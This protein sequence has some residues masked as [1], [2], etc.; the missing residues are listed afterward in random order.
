MA[1][2]QLLWL[3]PQTTAFHPGS[4]ILRGWQHCPL[5][6]ERNPAHE[7]LQLTS[8][9]IGLLDLS[10]GG[11]S[12]AKFLQNWVDHLHPT[13]WIGL[14]NEAPSPTS[15]SASF[16]SH[17]CVDYH[18][19][20][21]DPDRLHSYLGHLWGMAT[22]KSQ[23][24]DCSFPKSSQAILEGDSAAIVSCR[25]LLKRY[26]RTCEPVMIL[27]ASGTGKEGAAHFLHD[28]SCVSQGP[29]VAVD[30]AALPESL[31]QSELFGHEKG[32]FTG[33][34][35]QR[36]GRIEAAHG[37]TLLLD[38]I[39]E[40]SLKQ[41]AALLRFLQESQIEPVGSI[42][43]RPVDA[44]I[45]STASRS[46]EALVKDGCFRADLFYRLSVLQV[47]LPLLSERMEDLPGLIE[48]VRAPLAGVHAF[49]AVKTLSQRSMKC[50]FAHRWPGNLRELQNR[51]RRA[52]LVSESSVI[53]PH[54][55]GLKPKDADDPDLSKLTLKYC[56]A[57]SEQR[58]VTC[59][60]TMSKYNISAAAR[61]LNIS[62]LSL[63]R[64]MEKYGLKRGGL[65]NKRLFGNN[66]IFDNDG[67]VD[68]N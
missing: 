26:A 42:K 15:R 41:Q 44:R 66:F 33:A 47:N 59:A 31:T 38:G 62:R 27:G 49:V 56:R 5:D 60:L 54:H 7:R 61:L 30:C 64:L 34:N 68:P 13:Y 32:A 1:Q 36:I 20:P 29:F 2:R 65:E 10:V 43:P 14:L 50:L 63:Y 37:G 55:L 48:H 67:K 4:R 53:E 58:A 46:P 12:D 28:C 9:R 23:V 19:L 22:L 24:A 8:P 35:G 11:A 57:Q 17:Y 25:T 39:D 6:L 40:L 52:E 16:I 18:T 51:L 3:A 21:C 45:I